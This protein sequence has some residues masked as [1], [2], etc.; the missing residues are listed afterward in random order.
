MDEQGLEPGEIFQVQVQPQHPP[1]SPCNECASVF[2]TFIRCIL[3]KMFLI[4][5]KGLVAGVRA[6]PPMRP[7]E[8]VAAG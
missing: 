2:R 8:A 4:L 5:D 1:G 3:L 6:G 7:N